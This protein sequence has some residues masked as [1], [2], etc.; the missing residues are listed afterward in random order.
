[1]KILNL[2]T[3][4]KLRELVRELAPTSDQMA[5]RLLVVERDVV[6]PVKGVLVVILF[7]SF[8][9]PGWFED[10]SIVA[11]VPLQIVQQFFLLYLV[12]NVGVASI[13]L[14]SRNLR[15]SAAQHIIFPSNFLDGLFL[16]ALAAVTGGVDS[17]VYWMFVG[18]IVR[19]ALSTP[20][21]TPQ[22]GLN[23]SA[24]LCYLAAGILDIATYDAWLDYDM[25]TRGP[26][27]VLLEPLALRMFVLWLLAACCYGVQVLLENEQRRAALQAAEFAARQEQL[28]SASRLSAEVAHQI[29]NPLSTINNVVFSLQRALQEG[30]PVHPKQLGIIRSEVERADAI[31]TKL[32]GYAQLADAK[33]ERLDLPA[34]LDRAI[35]EVFPSGAK[36]ETRIERHY[37]PHLPALLM[38][39]AHLSEILVNVLLNAREA[40][41]GRG[42]VRIV[43]SHDAD[44][45]ILVTISDNGP[46]IP[47]DRIERIFEPYFSTKEKGTGLGLSIV[48]HTVEMYGGS[49]RAESELGKGASLVLYFP[50]RTFMKLKA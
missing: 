22:L 29:K 3:V 46:G 20:L 6:L 31:I 12:F 11:S 40:T 14:F 32:M 45:S 10:T 41:D 42:H 5:R 30:K 49:V 35:H 15:Y 18:L 37:A 44:E 50:T 39:R 43:A 33:V 9:F 16:A 34:E 7:T 47:P 23:I 4:R 26:L 8:Y 38:Q 36:Y 21:A 13:L 1:M 48:R 28:R 24:S 17:P 25:P 27:Q 19:N 2:E